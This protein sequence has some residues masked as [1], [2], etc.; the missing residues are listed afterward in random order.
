M[1]T[2]M[3]CIECSAKLA[4]AMNFCPDCGA[5]QA[6]EQTVTISVSEARVQ[7]GSRSPDELPPEFFEVGISSEMYKNANAPFD[8][9]AIPSDES[10]VPA[11]CAWAV[12][13]H[14]GPMRERKWNENLE[15]RFHLVAKYSGRRLSEITQYLGKPLAVAE[16]NGIKSVVWGSSGLSNIW[17]ANLIFDR[18]DICIGLM[19]IN[20]GKV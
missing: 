18:Y 16:D 3:L 6:S 2:T 19:G 15:T 20:E 1:A 9:E 13:K 5:K 12:M 14:P 4:D 8:S 11:N 7:Y 17:Q 10:L